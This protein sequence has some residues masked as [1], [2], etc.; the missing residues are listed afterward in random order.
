MMTVQSR[1]RVN[2]LI[3]KIKRN[4]GF[5][6]EMKVKDISALSNLDGKDQIKRERMK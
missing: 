5:A 3:L 4:Q 1:I 6:N 2:N